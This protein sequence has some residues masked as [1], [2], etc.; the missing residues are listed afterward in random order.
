[1]IRGLKEAQ[2]VQGKIRELGIQDIQLFYDE[3][4]QM[5]AVCQ[6]KKR[7]GIL[8]PKSYME[9]DIRPSIMWWVKDMNGVYRNPSDRD[10]SDVAV[11]VNRSKTWFEHGGGDRLADEFEKQDAAREQKHAEKFKEKIHKIAPDMKKAIR[12]EL[13]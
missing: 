5:W 13:T 9:D 3:E 7:G 6:V 11:T 8:L 12:K 4:L 1:M 2:Y 10:I